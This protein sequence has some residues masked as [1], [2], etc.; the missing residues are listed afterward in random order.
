LVICG[1]LLIKFLSIGLGAVFIR[2]VQNVESCRWWA[3]P[4]TE[5]VAA[6]ATVSA[7]T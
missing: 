1:C 7:L 5:P 6:I 3:T 4:P 2:T